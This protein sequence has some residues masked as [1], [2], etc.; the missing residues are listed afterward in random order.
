MNTILEALLPYFDWQLLIALLCL[1]VFCLNT[2]N[3]WSEFEAKLAKESAPKHYTTQNRYSFY[4]ILYTLTCMLIYICLLAFPGILGSITN[5]YSIAQLDFDQ[6]QIAHRDF[7]L[8]LLLTIIAILPSVPPLRKGEARLRTW[9]H[10]QAFIPSQ[11]AALVNRLVNDHE[12]FLSDLQDRKEVLEKIDA[13]IPAGIDPADPDKELWH[14]W[15]KLLYFKNKISQWRQNHRTS[16]FN[17]DFGR[18]YNDML[19]LFDEISRGMQNYSREITEGAADKEGNIGGSV[20]DDTQLRKLRTDMDQL[21]QTTYEYICCGILSTARNEGARREQFAFFGLYPRIHG[22]LPLV[23]DSVLAAMFFVFTVTTL[24]T[25]YHQ[26]AAGKA[27]KPFIALDIGLLHMFMQGACICLAYYL[28][29]KFRMAGWFNEFPGRYEQI[30]PGRLLRVVICT[31]VGYLVVFLLLVGWQLS[32]ASGA[33]LFEVVRDSWFWPLPVAVTTAFVTY[34]LQ[35]MKTDGTSS[36]IHGGIQ[37][38]VQGALGALIVFLFFSIR[39]DRLPGD[40]HYYQHPF[41]FYI[42]GTLFFTGWCIGRVFPHEYSKAL[43]A[44]R[45][46]RRGSNR[47]E[48]DSAYA[49]I[50]EQEEEIKEVVISSTG[51]A[52][53]WEAPLKK[54][55]SL[56]LS[57]PGFDRELPARVRRRENGKIFL[58]FMLSGIDKRRLDNYLTALSSEPALRL[59]T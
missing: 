51:A 13:Y 12:L 44:S 40:M 11:A 14:K 57:I 46:E 38:V 33:T 16:Q 22:Q 37:A 28:Y 48:I 47:V 41:F 58:A 23:V 18:T 54:G 50:G 26:F 6:N 29:K 7:P 43:R 4:A 32:H 21:L 59:A 53:V 45:F 24:M 31:A 8:V 5:N 56:K 52:L 15:F 20:N 30:V 10:R 27:I 19:P 55:S 35:V 34:Y 49:R 42:V 9:F 3:R 1:T 39:E 17:F 36:V 25:I 2:F